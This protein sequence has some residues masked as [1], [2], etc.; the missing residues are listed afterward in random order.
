MHEASV[1]QALLDQIEQNAK[2]YNA[3]SVSKVYVIIGEI[4]G[5]EPHLLKVAF[6]TF[7]QNTTASDSELII[8]FQKPEIYCFDCQR[9]FKLEKFRM[10]CPSCESFRV[11]LTKGDELILKTLELNT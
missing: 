1:V 8:E 7:K 10:K 9:E 3:T 6:D 4:S 11:K 2:I 5:V